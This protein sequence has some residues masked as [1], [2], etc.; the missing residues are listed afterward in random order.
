MKTRKQKV[1]KSYLPL[2]MSDNISDVPVPLGKWTAKART[3][4]GWC[5]PSLSAHTSKIL[6]LMV[7][8][9][10]GPGTEFSYFAYTPSE[11]LYNMP[12]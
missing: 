1:T 5:G 10:V 3:Y 12:I 4:T 6:Y 7:Q 11:C 8:L 2:K 9:H